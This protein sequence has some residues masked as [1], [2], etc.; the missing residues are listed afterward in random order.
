MQSEDQL[1]RTLLSVA[2]ET[3]SA[4]HPGPRPDQNDP[5]QQLVTEDQADAVSDQPSPQST[6]GHRVE[7]PQ[8]RDRPVS[9]GL[10]CGPLAPA[11]FAPRLNSP[12]RS[13]NQATMDKSDIYQVKCPKSMCAWTSNKSRDAAALVGMVAEL[14][15]HLKYEHGGSQASSEAQDEGQSER[16]EFK[17]AT[18]AQTIPESMDDRNFLLCKGRF[19]PGGVNW[20]NVAKACPLVQAPEL[21]RID[22][23]HIGLH[24]L[25][26][27]TIKNCHD[28]SCRS[29]KLQ[30]F[31][32]ENLRATKNELEKKYNLS[33]GEM[34]EGKDYK[35]VKSA[36]DAVMAVYNFSQLWRYIHPG[37][38]FPQAMFRVVLEHF[39]EGSVTSVGPVLRFFVTVLHENAN[40]A[41]RKELPLTYEENCAKWDL[42]NRQTYPALQGQ[43]ENITPNMSSAI[44]GLTSALNV[45]KKG[46]KRGSPGQ[47]VGSNKRTKRIFY[48]NTYNTVGGC[49]NVQSTKG[50]VGKDGS[51]YKHGCSVKVQPGNR[52]CNSKDHTAQNH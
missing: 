12:V 36:G 4:R 19:L 27:K 49:R 2:R 50:C 14:E 34:I 23:A 11:S 47:A 16:D 9:P 39:L 29:L 40:R 1:A 22:L 7:G 44:K 24:T 15:C 51:V 8:E 37:D 45:F 3:V 21:T 13:M 18:T 20:K 32:T 41:C 5:L 46:E 35:E 10:D 6:P 28:R 52:S 31:T 17:A 42:V 33:G 25:N 38:I 30:H 43:R 48:C 26:Q